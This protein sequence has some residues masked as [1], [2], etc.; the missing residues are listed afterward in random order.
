MAG[1]LSSR[2]LTNVKGRLRYISDEN[3]Q[4]NIVDYYN[5]TNDE[6][7]KLLAKE[8]QI[9][10]IEANARGKCCEARELIIGIPQD[11]D[12]TAQQL[13]DIFKSKYHVECSCAIHKNS[14]NG[15]TN[16]HCH[17]IFSERKRLSEPE[18]V[19]EK[20]ASRNYYYNEKGIK[21]KKNDA[22]K[23]VKEGDL[24]QKSSI[25]YFSNKDNFF[26][27]QKFVYDCKELFLNNTF[28]LN[29]SLQSEKANKDFSQKHIGKN[30]P[31]EEYI[32]QNNALKQYAKN[33]CMAGDIIKNQEEGTTLK[34]FKERYEI[35]NFSAPI[36]EE[37]ID[38]VFEFQNEMKKIYRD[39]V[40]SE[41]EN[42]NNM[43]DDVTLLKGPSTSYVFR[44]PQE[45]IIDRYKTESKIDDI[46]NKFHLIDFLRNKMSIIFK[47]LK[48][49]VNIQDLLDIENKNKIEV[50]KDK[51]DK[52]HINDCSNSKEL[53]QI[54]YEKDYDDLEF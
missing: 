50:V 23:V 19:E 53:I 5:T 43:V 10:H 8:N 29:W 31:K 49:L 28:R 4:E 45:E 21:C 14:K 13:C 40:E 34:D 35:D 48:E 37:N 17:L 12:F 15:V 46:D 52:L 11:L 22:I 25:R 16:K 2:K 1:Y 9:R 32:K 51:N 47:R 33:I 6:F 54:D 24:I 39:E 20:R 42:H 38:K 41:I 44:K 27:S 3:R 36:F 18:I 7:W 30:N 26:K